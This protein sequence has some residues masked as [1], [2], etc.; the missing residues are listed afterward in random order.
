[1]SHGP[2]ALQLYGVAH[3]CRADR[4]CNRI[5][6][7]VWWEPSIEVRRE[8]GGTEWFGVE[9]K[10]PAEGAPERAAG[11]LEHLRSVGLRGTSMGNE[12][13]NADRIPI[14]LQLYSVRK[15]C[16]D[17]L[18]GTLKAVAEMGYEGVEFAGYYG[19]SAE[20][21]KAMLDDVGLP[22]V[23]AHLPLNT[24]LGDNL[25]ETVRF[26]KVL[27]NSYL[28][29]PGLSA[30][31][32]ATRAAWI[33]TAGIFSD[34]ARSL[35]PLGMRVGYHNHVTEFAPLEGELPWDTFFSNASPEVIMQIDTGNAMYGGGDPIPCLA[36]YPGRATTVHLK[37]HSA[38]N[39]KA[40]IGEG[41][42][43]WERFFELCETVGNT[44][45]Y[46]VEQESYA[47]PPLECVARCL[48]NL[49][50]MGK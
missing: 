39:D 5:S 43:Q 15:D 45:W 10:G 20:D 22:A 12:G 37:E 2:I 7:G 31:R 35:E 17:D 44:R 16:A 46:I 29:V 47:Y 33:E 48:D 38:G 11:C 3:A 13:R 25:E 8:V 14:A 21:V 19:H 42:M 23:G 32:T 49:K 34:I 4:A 24:M 28:V 30:E 50:A 27:G 41:D 18:A 9:Q 1:M 40:I 6:G 26:Q 36:R